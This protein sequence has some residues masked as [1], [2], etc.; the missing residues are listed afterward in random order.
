MVSSLLLL[1]TLAAPPAEKPIKPLPS[2]GKAP[3]LDG[4]LKD[5]SPALELKLPKAEKGATVALTAK[6]T[7]FKD[8][9]YVAVQAKDDAFNEH[10]QLEVT[11]FFPG[12]G[13][14]SRGYVYRYGKDG[15]RLPSA[16]AGPPAH[17]QPRLKAAVKEDDKAGT[18]FELAFPARAL[19][20]FQAF[21]QLALSICLEYQ[22]VD[23]AGQDAVKTV[24]C[25]TGEMLGGPTRLPD[26]FRK[27][28]KLQPAADV[29]GIEARPTGWIGFSQ[30]HYPTWVV[31]DAE[32]TPESL[33]ELIALDN[34]IDPASVALPIPRK[35]VLGD[36]RPVF[37]L[38]TGQNPYSKDSCN[39]SNELRM[40]MYV[41][42][43]NVATRVLEW[44]AATCNL[45]RAMRFELE[46]E[47][48]QLLIG[49]TNGQMAR[50]V[51]TNEHFERSEL[52][53][54]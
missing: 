10:D 22:D 31:G 12:S 36:N 48:G 8:T 5:F 47:S 9:L 40:A 19:P 29:E 24:T 42:K 2:L 3:V 38:L 46:A 50:F 20:R 45:G 39:P 35:L 15:V 23:V 52:G 51:F 53:K 11:L 27:N 30:L 18:T 13:T 43:G 16:E 6:A 32:F 41:V 34:A 49:Y 28:L 17:A 37:T 33:A 4:A 1:V 44:P 25:P 54:R 21:S 7:F 26:E 14:T